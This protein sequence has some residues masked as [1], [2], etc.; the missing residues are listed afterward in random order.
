LS[1]FRSTLRYWTKTTFH[2]D[3]VT[4]DKAS[5]LKGTVNDLR[6]AL[7]G[8][9]QTLA[10]ARGT[11]GGQQT[12]RSELRRSTSA[13]WRPPTA[14]CGLTGERRARRG[15]GLASRARAS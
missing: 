12:P 4:T 15:A 1:S 10:S 3:V 14:S 6:K 5:L 7:A 11:L 2:E 8:F 13:W 9:D